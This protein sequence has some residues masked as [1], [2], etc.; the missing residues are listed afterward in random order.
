M[1]RFLE[2]AA[3]SRHCYSTLST[4]GR[5][6]R[7]LQPKDRSSHNTYTSAG[8]FLLLIF[9]QGNSMPDKFKYDMLD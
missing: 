9:S 8:V 3:F 4:G 5:E 7:N 2:V 1:T 6:T